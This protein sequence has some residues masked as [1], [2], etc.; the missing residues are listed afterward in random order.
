M[1][2]PPLPPASMTIDPPLSPSEIDFLTGFSSRSEVRRVW[3]DQ[4]SA[5]CP[6]VPTPDGTGLAL[7]PELARE[8]ADLVAPWLLYLCREFLAPSTIEAMHSA[9]AHGLRGGHQT[10]GVVVVEGFHE[11]AADRNRIVE[12]VLLPEHDAVVIPFGSRAVAAG[13]AAVRRSL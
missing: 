10:S 2:H 11:I 9:L 4:P 3:P 5:R 7:E 8:A 12:R 1:T 6:W 13:G